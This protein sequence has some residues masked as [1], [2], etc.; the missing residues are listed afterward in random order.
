MDYLLFFVLS[1]QEQLK[2]FDDPSCDT[3]NFWW[4]HVYYRL[5]F[6]REFS[7]VSQAFCTSIYICS[8]VSSILFQAAIPCFWQFGLLKLKPWRALWSIQ[9][10]LL[11]FSPC[12]LLLS[13]A[14]LEIVSLDLSSPCILCGWL[15]AA[16]LEV[17]QSF[18]EALQ[19]KEFDDPSGLIVW[20]VSFHSE[21]LLIDLQLMSGGFL[22]CFS[23]Y[24]SFC[25]GNLSGRAVSG[26][27]RLQFLVFLRGRLINLLNST[28]NILSCQLQ[29]KGISGSLFV[30]GG[31][32]TR[33][34][35]LTRGL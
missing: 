20:F 15:P 28:L 26:C 5:K 24:T 34:P 11:R 4:L 21:Y 22:I 2:E 17:L 12:S 6:D 16:F 31:S 3:S 23:F 32:D 9:L 8:I 25:E 29:P 19:L 35:L 10:I 1:C 14:C 18:E 30:S 33:G 7:S 27:I 13:V